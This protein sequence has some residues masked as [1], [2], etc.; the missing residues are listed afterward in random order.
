MSIRFVGEG[1]VGVPLRK[2]KVLSNKALTR[3][4]RGLSG[5]EG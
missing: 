1:K 4:V 5:Q 2:K 3:R